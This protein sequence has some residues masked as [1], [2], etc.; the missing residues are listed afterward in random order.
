MTGLTR[1]TTN[2]LWQLMVT[3]SGESGVVILVNLV[4]LTNLM[5]PVNLVILVYLANLVILANLM[6]LMNFVNLVNF[7]DIG[8]S[9]ESVKSGDSYE[10]GEGEIISLLYAATATE[11]FLCFVHLKFC[12]LILLSLFN[13]FGQFLVRSCLLE[14]L[15]KSLK[16]F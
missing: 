11:L 10:S 3:I 5:I 15:T 16:C 2:N 14:T 1:D 4:I 12:S 7:G 6:N 9:G 13:L 8:K